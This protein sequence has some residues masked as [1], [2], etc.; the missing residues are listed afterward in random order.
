MPHDLLVA[1]VE[2]EEQIRLD[3]NALTFQPRAL[4]G[5]PPLTPIPAAPPAP[6]LAPPTGLEFTAS[7][8]QTVLAEAVLGLGV[9]A[10]SIPVFD[11]SDVT[12][13]AS[14]LCQF[15]T[16]ICSRVRDPAG[17]LN[18]L[19][20]FTS[21]MAKKRLSSC[22][23]MGT[24]GYAAA[25]KILQAAYGDKRLQVSAFGKQIRDYGK[26]KLDDPDSMLE[27]C[28]VLSWAQ[29][30]MGI[31]ASEL[32]SE[33]LMVAMLSKLPERVAGRW[34]R[35]IA[36]PSKSR[37]ILFGEFLSFCQEEQEA[38]STPA[39]IQHR[40]QLK[41]T[42]ARTR[43]A[44]AAKMSVKPA[45]ALATGVAPMKQQL[46]SAAPRREPRS[47]AWHLTE[48]HATAECSSLR[49][50]SSD[51]RRE[52]I[53]RER[54]CWL[55]LLPGHFSSECRAKVVC[56]E[57]SSQQHPTALH[58]PGKPDQRSFGG[59]GRGG[60]TGGGGRGGGTGGGGR[61][62]GFGGGGRG[63]GTGGGGRGGGTGG[64]G[65]GGG[66]TD[67]SR[68]GSI[69]GG[70]VTS[71]TPRVISSA[72]T[73]KGVA[74]GL[75]R[76]KLRSRAG[77][78]A[79]VYALL[80]SGSSC[81]FVDEATWKA[82]GKSG[83]PGAISMTILHLQDSTKMFVMEGL[84]ASAAA[85]GS[86]AVELGTTYVRGSLPFDTANVMAIDEVKGWS[87]LAS[88]VESLERF[89]PSIPFGAI[90]G[91][92][93]PEAVTPLECI[94]G[95][96]GEP[97]AVRTALGWH[98][99]GPMKSAGGV[100]D[101]CHRAVVMELDDVVQAMRRQQELD[102]PDDAGKAFSQEDAVFHRKMAEGMR[103][104]DGHFVVSLPLRNAVATF[105]DNTQMALQRLESVRRGLLRDPEKFAKYK[106]TMGDLV[107]KGY[108][109]VVDPE[110]HGE[111]QG[112]TWYLPHHGVFHPRKPGKAESRLRLLSNVQGH[113]PQR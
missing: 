110:V 74:M 52:F 2:E 38:L 41:E 39:A 96:R 32:N 77:R 51:G 84:T 45:V 49:A 5:G 64:G 94:P 24:S 105:P 63:G 56:S 93:S 11:G 16:D 82:L 3:P 71:S 89:D 22:I 4:L 107:E 36:K 43:S 78:T 69:K 14:F 60:G 37:L 53:L 9:S 73:T 8:E 100:G 88:I 20:K 79:E 81:S 87:H 108:S 75:V 91:V 19:L 13:F 62:R 66:G 102:F 85:D 59:G 76:V 109:E 61:G 65:R 35:K 83:R 98:V 95:K 50:L 101:T 106:D 7:P 86:Q 46:S 30:A 23:H 47:C 34:L 21:G 90:I 27:Y 42:S 54:L 68:Q 6:V 113:L 80:D 44:P 31:H 28:L 92:N 97:F 72:V 70:S 57:C 55:C 29:A 10:V 58:P 99:A 17:R 103:H 112:R 12:E 1:G 40:Q 33:E 104:E 26:V 15:E 48:G 18:Q 67:G 25:M 111:P